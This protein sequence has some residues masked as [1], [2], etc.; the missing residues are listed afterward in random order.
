MSVSLPSPDRMGYEQRREKIVSKIT[1]MPI[2]VAP[3]YRMQNS[4]TSQT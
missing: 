3:T 4:K 1:G 2:M